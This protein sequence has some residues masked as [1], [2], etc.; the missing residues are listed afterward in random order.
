[1]IERTT[2]ALRLMSQSWDAARGQ[3]FIAYSIDDPE[4]DHNFFTA[5]G[6]FVESWYPVQRPLIMLNRL[7]VAQTT[8]SARVRLWRPLFI[9]NKLGRP[10]FV[11]NK[12]GEPH[13][14]G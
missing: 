2:K 10:L 6:A 14:S 3:V 5:G 12:G 9:R 8:V 4:I 13:P 7:H 11:R 1:M